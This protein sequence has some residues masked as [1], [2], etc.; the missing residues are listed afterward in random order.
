LD[1]EAGELRCLG[2]TIKLSPQPSKLLCLLAGRPGELITRAEA[3]QHLWGKSEFIDFELGLNHCLKRI[4]AA[5]RDN[6]HDPLYI[7]TVPRRGYRFVAA[8]EQGMPLGG[9]VLAALPFENLNRDPET[10]YLAD[11]FA[12]A[13]LTELSAIPGVRVI[14]RQS[15]LH[16]KGTAM[17][18]PEISRELNADVLVRGSVFKQGSRIRV[19]A[20]LVLAEPEQQVW[21][22]AYEA[23]EGDA[24]EIQ[25]KLAQGVVEAV[26]SKLPSKGARRKAAS[27]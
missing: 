4:R 9:L 5:L 15:V 22:Q 18:L 12:E 7:E 3:R 13:A 16:L 6:A 23:D 17:T 21:A 27:A 10:D 11:G 24:L 2:H 1:L 19:N 20:Q 14:S 25:R 8:V 26:R